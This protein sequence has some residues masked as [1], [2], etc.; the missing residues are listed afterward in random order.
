MKNKIC[1]LLFL[2]VLPSLMGQTIIQN[3]GDEVPTQVESIYERGLA[4]LSKTQSPKG[5]WGNSNTEG[6][7]SL[8]ILAYFAHG[9]EPNFGPHAGVI[10]RALKYLLEIQ[11]E[12]GMIGSS[13]YHHSYATLALAE[14]YGS[15]MDP[16][17]GPAL[18]KAVA[19]ILKSQNNNSLGVWRYSPNS[20]ND[21]DTSVAG[22]C[23]VALL[24][25]R[26][27]G[28]G[29]PQKNIDRALNYFKRCQGDDGSF[30]YTKRGSGN[31]ARTAIGTLVFAV[32]RRRNE[33]AYKK[34]VEYISKNV[35]STGAGEHNY[36]YMIYYQAQ[37]YFQ[38][39]MA[40]WWDWNKRQIATI[41]RAQ[42]KDGG[43]YLSDTNG[44]AFS[45]AMSLLSLALNF[46]YLPIYE[47]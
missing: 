2:S 15:L 47:R 18:E 17:L 25:A 40:N 41:K 36:S 24:A 22:A 11:K 7:T 16:K 34:A 4:Y 9:E 37:A 27:A 38:S 46:R 6:I 31:M 20:T 43:I 8:C 3:I 35:D 19:L 28:L 13:M 42:A 10:K 33:A 32:G 45:T 26:N 5:N 29:V 12:S 44:A 23:L 30:G 21:G 1:L 39:D 14:C